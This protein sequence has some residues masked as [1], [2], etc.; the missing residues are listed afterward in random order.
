MIKKVRL[1]NFFSFE[2]QEFEL[3]PEANVFVGING[4]GK[5]NVLKAFKLLQE[6]LK[7]GL[8]RLIY[9]QWGGYQAVKY[10][11][12]REDLPIRLTFELD[13][14]ALKAFNIP[15]NYGLF[16]QLEIVSVSNTS[17]YYVNEYLFAD[18][19]GSSPMIT[20]LR[21]VQGVGT[22]RTLNPSTSKWKEYAYESVD[23]Q[24]LALPTVFHPKGLPEI[25]SVMDIL[26]KIK[27]YDY[28]D[29]TTSS[30]I[31][32]PVIA[33]SEKSLTQNGSNLTQVLNTIKI[34][35]KDN[36]R[37]IIASLKS[38]NDHFAGIDFNMIGGN[39]ELMLEESQYKRSVHVTH[40]SDGTLRFL[41]LMA[42]FFNENRGSFICIDEPELGLHPDMISSIKKAMETS[43]GKTQYLI[44]THSDHLLDLFDLENIRVVE[45]D[46][47]NA[48]H[49]KSLDPKKFEGWYENFSP[50]RMWRMGDFGGNRY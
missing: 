33:T 42:I 31:R 27:V 46:D 23:H 37:Q 8:Q 47:N 3:H 4:S 34:E 49:V 16:Y 38:V 45:K 5:S 1:Q 28:F 39:I 35:D 40:V 17:N 30:L 50:G 19:Q 25:S 15:Q 26:A 6:G 22:I 18:T 2:G 43:Y 36:Y 21:M 48:S 7:R 24:E 11:G 12:A 29:T 32:R 41:C 20:F 13:H 14:S 10:L 44:T 9:D